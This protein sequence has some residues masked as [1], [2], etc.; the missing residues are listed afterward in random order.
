MEAAC[1]RIVCRLSSAQMDISTVQYADVQP[2]M[3]KRPLLALHFCALVHQ[4]C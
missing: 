3:A 4:I 2:E 1:L